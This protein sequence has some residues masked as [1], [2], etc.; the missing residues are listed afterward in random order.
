MVDGDGV[1][2]GDG[3]GEDKEDAGLGL[4]MWLGGMA[5]ELRTAAGCGRWTPRASK[6]CRVRKRVRMGVTGR[7]GQE[8]RWKMS[9]LR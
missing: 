3:D 4:D 8:E 6:L 5:V 2:D 1:V 9:A 7:Q